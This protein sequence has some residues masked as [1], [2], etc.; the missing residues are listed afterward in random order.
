M[1]TVTL[2]FLLILWEFTV[3]EDSERYEWTNDSGNGVAL[4]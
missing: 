2:H 1:L 4:A 3:L